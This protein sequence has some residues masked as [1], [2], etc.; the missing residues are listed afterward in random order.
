MIAAATGFA[1]CSS[2][3]PENGG[4]KPGTDPSVPA[5]SLFVINEGAFMQSNGSLSLYNTK[6]STISN[7]IFRE[8][9]GFGPGDVVQSMTIDPANPYAWLVVNNSQVIFAIDPDTFEER[10]RIAG[11]IVSPRQMLF[12][13]ESKAY[14][15]QFYTDDIAVVNP[16]TFSI[17][18]HIKYPIAEDASASTGEM[19]RV[20]EYVYV[21]CPNYNNAVLKVDTATDKV[22]D[23][24]YP[25]IQPAHI[26][27]DAYHHLWVLCDGGYDGSPY[28][29]EAPKLVLISTIDFEVKQE[30]TMNLGDYVSALA[31]DGTGER[32]YWINGGVYTMTI[33]SPSL[34][35][36]PYIKADGYFYGITVDPDNGE[37][38]VAD[39]VDFSQPGRLLRYSK[40]GQELLSTV[41]TGVC[42]HAFCWK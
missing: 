8:A 15:S 7:D 12:I 25:G 34:P 19:V 9:N 3:E 33:D 26:V 39:A 16:K 23:V 28:G 38:Y 14:V 13:N 31:I 30:Y 5:T 42:P 32:L 36:Q 6:T 2:D 29:Y 11:D 1:A 10:G 37:I 24:C 21:C 18:G 17:T 20:D 35:D 27:K 22:V 40:N 41:T 4:E